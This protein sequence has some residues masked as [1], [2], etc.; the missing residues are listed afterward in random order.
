M[1]FVESKDLKPG[2]RLARPI[3]NK[4]GVM[5]YDRNSFLTASGIKSIENFGL[6]GLFIL[7]PAEPLPPVSKEDLEFEQF[8]VI[9]MFRIKE[10]MDRLQKKQEPQ[11]LLQL[12]ADILKHYGSLNHK[13]NFVQTLR[14]SA[15]FVYK[16]SISTAILAAMIANVMHFSVSEK[17]SLVMAALLYDLGYLYVPR[18][19]LDKNEPTEEERHSIH[20]CRKKGFLLLEP[21]TNQYDLNPE[22]LN[23]IQQTYAI[24]A[25]KSPEDIKGKT[26]SRGAQVLAVADKFDHLTAMSL[27]HPPFSEVS[28]IREI[29]KFPDFYQA[30][31]VSALANCIHILPNGCSIDLSNGDKGIVLMENPVNFMAPVVLN[32]RDNQIYDLGDPAVAG[33]IQI[34]DIMKTMDNRIIVDEETLK[35]F[36]SDSRLHDTLNNYQKKMKAKTSPSK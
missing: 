31:A 27:N 9:Y 17:S 33:K 21:T 15:D 7:E 34:M 30:K 35:Q 11:G 8:Q 19:I 28:A 4:M 26:F 36:S 12:T 23:I 24:L 1:Q 20:E 25:A 10:I 2:M 6:I 32:I 22:V 16:H 3:Y 18:N 13:M 29:R 14:G 5:L